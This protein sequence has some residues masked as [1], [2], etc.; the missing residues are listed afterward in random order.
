MSERTAVKFLDA[1]GFV[2]CA[3]S[4]WTLYANQLFVIA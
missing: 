4:I 2:I 3:T 1:F